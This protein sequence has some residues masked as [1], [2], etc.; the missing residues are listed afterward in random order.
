M[1]IF[2]VLIVGTLNIVCFFI[3]A[4]V[5]QKVDRG[6]PVEIPKLNP[7]KAIRDMRDRKETDRE[8]KR[9]ADVLHNI[10]VYDGT[11]AGQRDVSR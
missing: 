2:L 4:K 7:M 11:S 3:G 9:I 1:E 10:D 5:G 8:Q 6:E